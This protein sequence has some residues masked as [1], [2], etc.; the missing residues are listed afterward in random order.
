MN[1]IQKLAIILCL[2]ISSQGCKENSSNLLP[3]Q[4]PELSINKRVE[5]LVSRMTIDEKIAQLVYWGKSDSFVTKEG[6][7]NAES[8]R[9]MLKNGAGLVGFMRLDLPPEKYANI[10]NQVQ[11]VMMD[12]TRLKIPALFFGEGL[13][14]YM[15]KNATS[16]PI[17]PALASTW[18]TALV[19]Q[20]FAVVAKEARAFGVT[21]LFTPVLGLAREP[22]W[23]RVEETYSE[24]PFINAQMGLAAILGM[25]GTS[26][27]ID[28][29]HVAATAK[30]YAVHSQPEGGNNI[31]P[32]NFSER[33]IRESFLYPFEI[34]VKKGHVKSVMASYNEIDGIP[35]HA[36]SWLL[37]DVLKNEWA[38]LV[39]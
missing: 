28:A 5:D 25:Q 6:D 1:H 34:A 10:T 19:R 9:K 3:Y 33:V 32:G 29:D 23:G 7:F 18:D 15:G 24:D 30:H 12:E 16:F 26:Q 36:N 2:G 13:H 38:S 37:R 8:T 22:R 21:Q 14:G 35:S 31:A 17:P 20:A 27:L 11:K 4:N 39:L